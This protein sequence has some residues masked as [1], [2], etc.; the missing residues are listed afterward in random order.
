L[1]VKDFWFFQNKKHNILCFLGG[2][3]RVPKETL[4]DDEQFSSWAT[5]QQECLKVQ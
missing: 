4:E 5:Q 1:K 2:L 3:Q